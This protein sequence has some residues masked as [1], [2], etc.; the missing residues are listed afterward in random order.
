V[1]SGWEQGALSARA[2]VPRP[3]AAPDIHS[4]RALLRGVALIA[5]ELIAGVRAAARWGA[6]CGSPHR[7]ALCC[8]V[9]PGAVHRPAA[10]SQGSGHSPARS[11]RSDRLM[12]AASRSDRHLKQRRPRATSLSVTHVVHSLVCVSPVAPEAAMQ[13]M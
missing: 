1:L 2:P 11:T 3:P 5:A 4:T 6:H 12:S 13:S 7:V 10:S 9:Q 8:A